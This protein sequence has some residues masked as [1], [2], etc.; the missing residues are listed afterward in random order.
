M[1]PAEIEHLDKPRVITACT[2]IC[3]LKFGAYEPVPRHFAVGVIKDVDTS[4]SDAE[5]EQ[6]YEITRRPIAVE[7]PT[8]ATA[9]VPVKRN[10][11]TAVKLTLPRPLPAQNGRE[12]VRHVATHANTQ[13][14]FAP[15]ATSRPFSPHPPPS[16]RPRL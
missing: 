5:I 2:Q 14:T 11:R 9:R 8:T 10:A 13:L 1:A 16:P 3:G 4:L 15:Q 7:K 12:K 6:H